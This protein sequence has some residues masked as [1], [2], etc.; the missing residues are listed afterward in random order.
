MQFMY[1]EV[2]NVFIGFA[3]SVRHV[4]FGYELCYVFLICP[5]PFSH[6][7][8]TTLCTTL[9]C[10]F[11][12]DYEPTKADSYR[13]KLV[14]EGDTEESAI[15]IL[16]TAGQEDYAA[17]RDNYFRTGEGTAAFRATNGVVHDLPR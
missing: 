7:L 10:Q 6:V 9:V 11:V 5:Q 17:I 4:P 8:A 13:K 2:C 16:D 1:S 14:L 12:E 15:D 3:D